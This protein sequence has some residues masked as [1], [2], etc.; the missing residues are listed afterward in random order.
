MPE[1]RAG[2]G[3]IGPARAGGS[4]P[5]TPKESNACAAGR[6]APN[7]WARPV[8]HRVAGSN[9]ARGARISV[10]MPPASRG[11]PA[12]MAT[13]Q[14]SNH[15]MNIDTDQLVQIANELRS[16]EKR[17]EELLAELARIAGGGGGAAP[18][19]RRRGRPP[20]SRNQ[21]KAKPAVAPAKPAAPD[22][23][24]GRGSRPTSWGC[25][26]TATPTPR[27]H[28]RE[29][30]AFSEEEQDRDGRCHAGAARQ[31]GPREEGQAAR[32]P[33]GVRLGQRVV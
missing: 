6:F 10:V 22:A 33:G 4:P 30:P 1:T 31:R 15:R 32:V 11:S 28:R 7:S 8:N 5:L 12:R 9:P 24:R 27:G 29:A 3:R 25:W 17:R 26:P 23:S 19:V 16:L 13:S 2:S 18:A 21:A 20:G 14:R